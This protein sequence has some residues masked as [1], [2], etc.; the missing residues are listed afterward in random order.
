ML[1][2]LLDILSQV[3]HFPNKAL[4]R[5]CLPR[6]CLDSLLNWKKIYWAGPWAAQEERLQ[7]AALWRHVSPTQELRFAQFPPSLKI[8]PTP[9]GHTS[10]ADTTENVDYNDLGFVWFLP[11][12]GDMIGSNKDEKTNA[13]KLCWCQLN[14]AMSPGNSLLKLF[15]PHLS[16]CCA[17]TNIKS[18]NGIKRNHTQSIKWAD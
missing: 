12:E 7:T 1:R 18:F 15:S 9:S 2:I 4:H 11:D 16:I 17:G 6:A 8:T 3:I 13:N 5:E 14:V 10:T